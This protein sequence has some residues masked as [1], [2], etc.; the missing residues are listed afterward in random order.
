M[1]AEIIGYL[2]DKQ[3]AN[4]C[5]PLF[6]IHVS[7]RSFY[8]QFIN[9]ICHLACGTTDGTEALTIIDRPFFFA[10]LAPRIY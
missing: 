7:I 5:M 8:R 4:A 10:H 1:V 3:S 9:D 2:R 6:P